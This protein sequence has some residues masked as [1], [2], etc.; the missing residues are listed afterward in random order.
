MVLKYVST[1]ALSQQLPLPLIQCPA[2]HVYMH[3][4]GHLEVMLALNLL[5]I[6]FAVL[7]ATIP[8]MPS[9]PNASQ[10]P[11]GQQMQPLGG[12]RKAMAMFSA[13]IASLTAM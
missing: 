5:V 8:V 2:V 9:R 6:M 11:A 4:R 12:A 13:R 10:S 7:A 3:E 1:A